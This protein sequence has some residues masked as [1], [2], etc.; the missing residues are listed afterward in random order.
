MITSTQTE[1]RAERIAI[2]IIDAGLTE[3]QAHVEC[4]KN[5]EL[6]GTR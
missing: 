1:L 3:E 4:D 6:Y 5:P 2:M